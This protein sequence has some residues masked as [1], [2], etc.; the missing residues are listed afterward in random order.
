MTWNQ[1]SVT[2]S[3]PNYYQ[4]RSQENFFELRCP[5]IYSKGIFFFTFHPKQNFFKHLAHEVLLGLFVLLEGEFLCQLFRVTV[6]WKVPPNSSMWLT[7]YSWASSSSW[8]ECSSASFSESLSIEKGPAKFKR[9]AHQVLLGLV[10]ILEGEFLCQLFRVTVDWKRPAKFKCVAHEV[11]LG[12]VILL[13]GEFL[14]QLFQITVNWKRSR[15]IQ[16]NGSRGT[17]GPRCSGGR[18]PLPAFLS[19]SQLKSLGLQTASWLAEVQWLFQLNGSI[20]NWSWKWMA[21]KFSMRAEA[22][23]QY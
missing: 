14:C 9:V 18:V 23:P 8:R 21:M 6:D 15:Q 12:L 4:L 11:V 1:A 13:E 10:I 17:P 16:G 2:H 5:N 20:S 3:G 19:H 7:R 22:V